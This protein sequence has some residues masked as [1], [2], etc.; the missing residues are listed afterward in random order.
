MSN[1]ILISEKILKNIIR[2]IIE[3]SYEGFLNKVSGIEYSY[4]SQEDPT[5]EK[6]SY[7]V[8]S[9]ARL[10][11]R[12]F[13]EEADQN[14]FKKVKKVHWF[15]EAYSSNL[16][17]DFISRSGSDLLKKILWFFSGN[18]TSEVSTTGYLERNPQ[19]KFGD[20]GIELQGF[21]TLA[22]N[23]MSDIYTGWAGN[24]SDELKQKYEKIGIR[25]R[26]AKIGNYY[27]SNYA[28]DANSFKDLEENEIVVA[29]WK[30]VAFWINS[31]RINEDFKKIINDIDKYKEEDAYK[32]P[33]DITYP[34]GF[35]NK[36]LPIIKKAGI[37][38]KFSSGQEISV[39]EI[40]DFLYSTSEILNKIKLK[41]QSY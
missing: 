29:N 27:I 19:S 30:P 10:I 5:F 39:K 38:I 8:K 40:E 12:I 1:K 4:Y 11:K 22:A 6:A 24:I 33:K 26:A 17:D 3:E 32:I 2:K 20:F 36:I 14:F 41:Q 21:V 16:Y 23:D 25:K 9:K 31:S 34:I 13:V 28:L 15:K 35:F 37:P 7:D 18:N